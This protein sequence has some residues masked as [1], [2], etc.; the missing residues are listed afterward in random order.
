M[1]KPIVAFSF[2]LITYH[3]QAQD[4]L[5]SS[6]WMSNHVKIDGNPA[7]WH[8]PLHFY[9]DNTKLF[10]AFANDDS[11]LYLCF[12]TSDEINQ[13][14]IMRAGMEVSLTSKAG[15][16]H[17]IMIS[18]PLAQQYTPINQGEAQDSIEKKSQK[19]NMKNNFLAQ[20]TMMEVKGFTTRNGIIAINDSSGIN[21]AI[22]WDDKNQ[23]T[24]EAAIPLKEFL[25]ADF[26]VTNLSNSITMEVTINAVKKQ[27]SGEHGGGGNS[28]GGHSRGGGM[29]GGHGHHHDGDTQGEP[30]A[31]SSSFNEREALFQKTELKQKF[32]L[33]EA[34]KN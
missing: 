9:D 4:D 33:G 34:V 27:H 1:L 22:N 18:F 10:Y 26:T 14:K 31:S 25:G 29:G 13:Q 24:Y 7:E 32:I 20:N 3:L 2:F 5:P 28:F 17:K 21:T 16:K 12:Q 19:K 30:T 11:N 6:V 8:K 23:L 15:D